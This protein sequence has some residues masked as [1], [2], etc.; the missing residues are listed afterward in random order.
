MKTAI[1]ITIYINEGDQWQHRPLYM[2]ILNMLQQNDLSGGT[3]IRAVAG[4]THL[5]GVETTSL[6]DIDGKLP[7]V[8]EFVDTPMNVDKVL[9]DLKKMVGQRL[10]TREVVEVVNYHL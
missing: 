7:L 3:M 8:L 2:E 5:N 6:V 4:F 10:I 1:K 9:P